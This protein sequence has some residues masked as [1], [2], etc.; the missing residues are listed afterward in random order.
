MKLKKHI[1]N[2]YKKASFKPHAL[3]RIR[4]FLTAEKARILANVSFINSQFNYA[5]LIWMFASKTAINNIFKIYYGTL[6]V[7]YSENNKSYE[8][9]F[10]LKAPS[11]VVSNLRSGT[12]GLRVDSG[13]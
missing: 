13:C 3:C 2:Q 5:P 9:H 1:E 6:Q 11:L 8:E 7:V 10:H 4:K 12:K